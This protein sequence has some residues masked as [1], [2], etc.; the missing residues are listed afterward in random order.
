MYIPCHT[1]LRMYVHL[2]MHCVHTLHLRA[3][4]HIRTVHMYVPIYVH[5]VYIG[6]SH[7]MNVHVHTYVSAY[8][9]ITTPSSHHS[10]DSRVHECIRT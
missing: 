6:I 5:I 4:A 7:T 8:K 9:S 10:W 2:S 1:E 3:H